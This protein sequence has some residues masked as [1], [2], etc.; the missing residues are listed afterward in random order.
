MKKPLCDQKWYFSKLVSKWVLHGSRRN[1]ALLTDADKLEVSD[2][3]M[4]LTHSVKDNLPQDV[5]NSA[6]KSACHAAD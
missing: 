2:T 3:V 4:R 6:D 5:T 1:V